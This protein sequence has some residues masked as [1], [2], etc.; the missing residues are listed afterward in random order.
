MFLMGGERRTR[1][2]DKAAWAQSRAGM[3]TWL[4]ART[5]DLS[6][7][8]SNCTVPLLLE[9]QRHGR[10]DRGSTAAETRPPPSKAA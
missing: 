2:R 3:Y 6:T 1:P 10:G 4:Q 5:E 8:V 9:P 7:R